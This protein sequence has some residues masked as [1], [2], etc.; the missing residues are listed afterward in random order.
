[1]LNNR[2]ER[3]LVKTLGACIALVFAY[4]AVDTFVL[5]PVENTRTAV[6]AAVTRNRQLKMDFE[7]VERAQKNLNAV[8]QQSLPADP[9]VASLM[10]QDWL[11]DQAGAAKLS[12]AI[13][14]PSRPIVE[15]GIG[16]RIPFTV[17]ATATLRHIGQFLDVFYQT[18]ILHR[19]TFLT[20]NNAGNATSSRRKL[21]ISLEAL[22][23]QN[24]THVESIPAAVPA[25]PGSRPRLGDCFARHDPFRRIN[26]A[27]PKRPLANTPPKKPAAAAS[28]PPVDALQTIRLVASI[29]HDGRRQAWFYDSRTEQEII[30]GVGQHLEVAEFS[31]RV[32]NIDSDSIT[33]ASNQR[34][35]VARLG[36]T[37]RDS[38]RNDR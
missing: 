23:L 30:V 2:R 35:R 21:T 6:Q 33:L 32:T 13:V 17:Q 31:A 20:I 1:M 34:T 4:D 25:P 28:A 27:G 11:M 18:P 26:L 14:T 3:V 29:W 8:Q 36:E 16:H 12:D 22:A 7:L 5:K 10:Y 38:I 24:A 9:S 15:E 37:L 19:I